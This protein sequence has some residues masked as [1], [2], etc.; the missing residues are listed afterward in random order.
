MNPAPAPSEVW[1]VDLAVAEQRKQACL[2]VLSG[3]EQERADRFLRPSDR[4]RFIVSHAA[5]R[6]VLGRAL[7]ADPGALVFA[8]G[9]AGKPE[10]AGPWSG[11]LEINLSHSGECALVGLSTHA[12]IGVDIEVVR[13]LPDAL[14]MARNHF[15]AEEVAALE[16]CDPTTLTRA[17]LA[18]WTRKEAFVKASGVGLSVP[19]DRFSVTIPPRPAAIIDRKSVV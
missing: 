4:D 17:F 2:A 5:S 3:E 18:C 16:R 14:R 8:A 9:P 1:V 7:V 12:R 11:T 15:A 10:L 13:D 6:L 19:L